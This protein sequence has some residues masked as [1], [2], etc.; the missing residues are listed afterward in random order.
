MADFVQ[1]VAMAQAEM[2]HLEHNYA[3]D[4]SSL[5]SPVMAPACLFLCGNV[6][7]HQVDLNSQ[8]V[9]QTVEEN[10]IVTWLDTDWSCPGSTVETTGGENLLVG[11]G[12]HVDDHFARYDSY[13]FCV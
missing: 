8:D 7:S 1:A 10:V 3:L 2:I 13:K 9:F 4:P 12:F 6:R 5:S 11:T